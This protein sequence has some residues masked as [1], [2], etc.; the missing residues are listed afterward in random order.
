[1]EE[2]TKRKNVNRGYMKLEVWNEAVRLLRWVGALLR[3]A[4]VNDFKL[5][6]QL[7]NAAQ[8]ISSNIAEGYCRTSVREYLQFVGI[9][10]G[11]SGELFTRMVGLKAIDVI[12]QVSFEEFDLLHY[13]VENKLLAL[14]K[15]LQ[16][17]RRDGTWVEEL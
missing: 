10:L 16:A 4:E 15:S 17:K 1:M 3:G 2:Y 11:S 9:A 13:S 7:V 8:S 12:P 14:K 5:C 6:S